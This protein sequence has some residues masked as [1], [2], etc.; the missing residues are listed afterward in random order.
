MAERSQVTYLGSDPITLHPSGDPSPRGVEHGESFEVDTDVAERLA[1]D[2]RFRV[3]GPAEELSDE[4]RLA[5]AAEE[6][7]EPRTRDEIASSLDADPDE[8]RGRALNDELTAAG[9]STSGSLA[10]RR[11]RLSAWQA[12]QTDTA[13]TDDTETPS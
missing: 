11:E 1:A 12:A 2:D 10:D 6:R 9:L 7:P 5:R 8:L 13:S 3:D 4:E